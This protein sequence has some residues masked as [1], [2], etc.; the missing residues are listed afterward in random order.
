MGVCMEVWRGA[1][2]ERAMLL[3]SQLIFNSDERNRKAS[4]KENGYFSSKC[5]F[6]AGLNG[7]QGQFDEQRYVPTYPSVGVVEIK[8]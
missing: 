2:V 8:S 5:L 3:D 7:P 6:I 1:G 4:S